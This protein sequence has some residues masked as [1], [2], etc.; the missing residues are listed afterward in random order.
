LACFAGLQQLGEC[1]PL[2]ARKITGRNVV[3]SDFIQVLPAIAG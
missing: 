2:E 3:K 1:R